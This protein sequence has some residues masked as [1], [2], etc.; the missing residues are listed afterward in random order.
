[1]KPR[2]SAWTWIWLLPGLSL[3]Y[4]AVLHSEFMCVM[5][6]WQIQVRYRH[7]GCRRGERET[8]WCQ[9]GWSRIGDCYAVWIR[10][11]IAPAVD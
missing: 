5:K 3:V 8:S 4:G 9:R 7:D 2:L 6:A 1:L 11:C 10:R